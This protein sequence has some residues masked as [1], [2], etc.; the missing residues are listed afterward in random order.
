MGYGPVMPHLTCIGRT[1]RELEAVVDR[2]HA[3]GHRNLMVLRGDPPK[4]EGPFRPPPDGLGHASD[5]VGL[6]LDRRPDVCCGVAGYPEVHPE[7]RSPELDLLYLKTKL[8]SGASFV[9]TQLFFDNTA[10]FDFVERCRRAGIYQPI[11]P[12]LLPAVSLA[13]VRRI[14]QMCRARLPEQ[15]EVDLEDAG[16]SGEAAEAVG[17]RWAATQIRGL[18]ERGV[19]GIHLYI[20]NRAR[21]A[22]APE[23]TRVFAPVRGQAA[24]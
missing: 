23:L 24:G 21:T 14:T 22:L 3:S 12:G 17:I 5:L 20:L 18:L 19:P 4:G 2:F 11:L 7:A 13:Q 16:G 15:L 10:Y 8:M 6:V 1:R 9:T